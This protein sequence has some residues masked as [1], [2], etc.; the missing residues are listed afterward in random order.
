[1]E[2]QWISQQLSDTSLFN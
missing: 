1:M 2:V